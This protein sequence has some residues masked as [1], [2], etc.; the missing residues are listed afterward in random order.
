MDGCSVERAP[1]SS[2]PIYA[3]GRSGQTTGLNRVDRLDNTGIIISGFD[4]LTGLT[5]GRVVAFESNNTH[6]W[7]ALTTNSNGYYASS[8][9]QGELLPNSSVR[10]E[11][12]YSANEDVINSLLLQGDK[13]W[14]TTVG[15]GLKSIDLSN[16]ILSST[17][18]AL[19]ARMDGMVLE[20]DGTMYVGLMGS[21]GSA[22][23]FQ[24][25]N[26]N[27]HTWGHGSLIAGLPNNLV[28]DFL[29]YGDHIMV[30]TYGGIGLWNLTRDDWDDPITTLDGLPTPI[31]EHLFSIDTPI[32]G[33]GRVLAGGPAGVTV[34][35]QYNLSVISTIDFGDGLVGNKVSGITFAE[36]TSRLVTNDDGSTM[37]LHHDAAVFISHDGQGSTR[38][39][40]AA[41]DIA[42]DLANGTYLIDMIP[43]NDVRA[44]AIDDWGV[45]IATDVQPLVHWNATMMQMES[46]LGSDS[47]LNWPPS[48]MTSDGDYVAVI[49]PRGI[50]VVKSGD[51][52]SRVASDILVGISE[53]YLDI[54]GL[55]V[56]AQ[57]G[58]HI[59]NPV[60][61]LR[62]LD[63][64]YQRR[65]DPLV[66][67][68]SGNS[69][70]ITNTS[71]PGMSTVL[72]N[73]ENPIL[74][75]QGGNQ[76]VPGKLPL[77]TGALTLSASQP[78]A[79]VWAESQFLNY[80]GSWDL[81][82]MN[83]NIE[84]SFQSAI[85]SLAPGSTSAQLH[86][87]LQS[88]MNGSIQVRITY[89]WQRVEVPTEMT[90]LIDRPNDG[91]G[92]LEASWLP[93]EDAAWH[94]YR[95]YVWDSTDI[96]DWQP[97]QDDLSDFS[98][99]MEFPFWSQTTATVTT[100]DRDGSTVTL[101]E[102]RDYRAAIAIAYADGSVGLPMSWPDS[103]TPTD[104]VPF[105]PDWLVAEPVSGG[106]AGTIYAE[107]SA[108]TEIDPDRT[109][110]WAVQQQISNA[111]ALSDEIDVAYGAGNTTVLQLEPGKTYWLAAVCVDEAGQSDATNA[112]IFGPVVTAGGL[113]D[114]IPPASITD[115]TAVDAPD[116]EGGRILVS[117]TPND[118]EDCTYHT[119]YILPASGFQP[120]SIVDG[121]PVAAYLT[122]CTTDEI[123]I[124]SIGD[125]SLENGVAYWIGV[126]AADDWGNENLN[127]VLVVDATPMPN[128]AGVGEPP[129]RVEGL[130]G[131][132][133]PSDDGT[134]IDIVWNRSLAADFS[135]YVIWVSDYP[136]N[137]LTEIWAECSDDLSAC[138]L[139][140]VDQRQIGG[141]LQMQ[142]T[143]TTAL[144]GSTVAT[145]TSEPITPSIP[146]YVTITTHDILGNVHLTGMEE[147]MVLVSPLD[148]RGDISPPDRLGVPILNDRSPDDG[149][150][151]FV[152]F[153]ES[154]ASDL[155]ELSLIHI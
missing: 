91:G 18:A 27:S 49:N 124:D 109:R 10:W 64:S 148:N 98:T 43:S 116:D 145:L 56:V 82:S 85:S 72:V 15:R 119:V 16:R 87:R 149:D 138:G 73:D 34:L 67:L 84:A 128:T 92:V 134:A 75:P 71:H 95:L 52:H 111:V 94:T 141:A 137:D 32:Q 68:Y 61:N 99:F 150:A 11:F 14:V 20:D 135:H 28:R 12:G 114:G 45:H 47:L 37:V 102:D 50:D 23:G 54:S 127:D 44:I 110:I 46:G 74:I 105:P 144:Y 107:W 115:T 118:E 70:D 96:P 131:W 3:I 100:A 76:G 51:D 9:L 4:E 6:V 1:S 31:I 58:L 21:E 123:I 155:H 66:A 19:H 140:E 63:R 57:D 48:Q 38:P 39:G 93:A 130:R 24:T 125:S 146:L 101:S 36:A 143:V 106:T 133:H 89:D 8:I 113:D 117:W 88:P 151:M 13:L 132:D 79:W 104:E 26:T 90:S 108:C 55:Y 80:S 41:W 77:H 33:N 136:L 126:V 25:F 40:A 139:L 112:T 2:G 129:A 83:P 65:A 154:E 103:A 53:A 153:P 120:P 81:A 86:I 78:G 30:A 142:I 121:W 35:D 97:S 152:T 17:P 122:D 42:T 7:V 59:F 29:E 147:H 69:W 5:S 62:E 22:A 60:E